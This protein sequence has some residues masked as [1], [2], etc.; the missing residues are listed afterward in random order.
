MA[1]T[2]AN[3][4]IEPT[5]M[6]YMLGSLRMIY[7]DI[8]ATTHS[9]TILR[10][11]L[12]NGVKFL[13][14]RWL[15]KYQVYVDTLLTDPQPDSVPTGYVYANTIDGQAYIPSGL[16]EG[17]V[18]RNPFVTFT[19][20]SPPII[21]SEDETAI[22]L[23]AKLLLRRSQVSSSASSFVSWKTEDISYSNLGSERSLTK[24][25]ESDQKELDDYFRSKIATP[26][27]S[28]FPVAYIPSLDDLQLTGI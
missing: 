20:N 11:A 13:Q 18:F 16:A 2:I 26:Q 10:T 4:N 23:A 15:S 19:Q 21:Q 17:S 1:N 6:D 7:G 5:N 22:L 12:V 8:T 25:L 28:E 3:F 24:I 27:R 14:R 9:D